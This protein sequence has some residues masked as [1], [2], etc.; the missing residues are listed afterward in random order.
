[1]EVESGAIVSVSVHHADCGDTKTLEET[2]E[3]AQSKLETLLGSEAPSVEHP[4]E[5]IADKRCHSREV[6]KALPSAFSQSH[7]RTTALGFFALAGG[8]R[9][10]GRGVPE[11]GAFG[12]AQG[13]GVDA[14]ACRTGG[15]EFRAQ[16]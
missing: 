13:Q 7:Q 5:V 3:K 4:A 12:L 16:P 14:G 8:Y 10:A 9:G 2:L 15:A 11:S 6:L 1:M